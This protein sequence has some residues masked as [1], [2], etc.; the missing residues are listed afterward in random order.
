MKKTVLAKAKA[1]ALASLAAV[2]LLAAL[3]ACVTGSSKNPEAAGYRSWEGQYYEHRFEQYWSEKSMEDRNIP[4]RQTQSVLKGFDRLP[5]PDSIMDEQPS[6]QDIDRAI[7]AYEKSLELEPSGTWPFSGGLVY[8]QPPEGGVKAALARAQKKKQEW[9]G[10]VNVRNATLAAKQQEQAK[11]QAIDATPNSPN[12]F[13]IVQNRDGGITITRYKGS[14][15]NVIIPSTISG[16]RVTEIA[17][18]FFINDFHLSIEI[19]SVVIPNTVTVIG[20]GAFAYQSKLSSVTLPDS[21]VSIEK[22]A[23]ERCGSL[24]SIT[25]PNSVTSIGQGAF[26]LAGLTSVTLGNRLV[27]IEPEAFK[28]NELTSVQIPASVRIVGKDAFRGNKIANLVISEGPILLDSYSF[29]GNPLATVV[30]PA[31]LAKSELIEELFK[32]MPSFV[33]SRQMSGFKGAFQRLVEPVQ[34]LTRITM[35]ANAGMDSYDFEESFV[36]YY[37]LQ[38]RKAGTYV[39]VDRIWRLQ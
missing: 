24:R 15:T 2:V 12:D 18:A 16:L 9:V 25:I 36:N 38:G 37:M 17:S 1:A 3:A 35:P 34:N 5:K 13:D 22:E 28:E 23:F 7:S 14:R 11:Q 21:L 33:G 26:W 10:V 30:I 20:G 31:S 4:R 8:L 6:E 19:H 29:S 39:K 32:P 27:T